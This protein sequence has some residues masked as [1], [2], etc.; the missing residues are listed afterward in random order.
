MRGGGGIIGTAIGVP[1]KINLAGKIK[2]RKCRIL[3]N[4]SDCKGNV[5]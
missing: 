4:W 2:G 1:L 5:F 3:G